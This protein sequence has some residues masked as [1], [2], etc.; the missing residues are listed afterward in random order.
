VKMNRKGSLR[1]IISVLL[2][3][4]GSVIAVKILLFNYTFDSIVPRTGYR[5]HTWM[6]FTG[7]GD[8]LSVKTFIPVNGKRQTISG[9]QIDSPD[10]E[11][12]RYRTTLHSYGEWIRYKADGPYRIDLFY[13]AKITPI[14]YRID[15]GL[16]IT[17]PSDSSLDEYL[18][19][20]DVIQT[21]DPYIHEL[22]GRVVGDNIYLLDILRA[23]YDYVYAMGTRPFKGTTDALTAAKLGEASC[24]GKSRL[25]MAMA[26]HLG[27]PSRL[28]GGLILN[29]GSKK[30]SH[31]WLEVYISGHWVPFDALNGHFAELPGNYLS[32]YRGDEALFRHSPN[33]A[34]DYRFAI[35]RKTVMNNRLD[36]Y[37][38][39]RSFN[40]FSLL[41]GIFKMNISFSVLQFLLVIPLGVVVVT[42][43]RNV[44]G[45]NTFGTF[46]PAL[47]AMS[48]QNTG[49]IPGMIVFLLVILLTVIVRRPLDKLGLLHTPKLA[50]MMIIVIFSLLLISLLSHL[51]FMDIMPSINATA[52]FPIAILTITSE[53]FSISLDED[54][55]K[56]TARIMAQTL[57][58][59]SL[60]Y[61][62]MNSIAVKSI[63]ISFPELLLGVIAFNLWIGSW[64]GIRV[65]ELIRFRSLY[66]ERLH[67]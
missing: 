61:V 21:D 18:G 54:G 13:D 1:L 59:M 15:P 56:A 49:L 52:L 36:S 10:L 40:I 41:S 20:T 50:I 19:A 22:T 7:N 31:Q 60:C 53:R 67:E 12:H 39:E 32:L 63:M 17:P 43:S 3:I 66:L 62:V 57:I 14:A 48:M 24:N 46:L 6:T 8:D 4:M 55:L 23:I 34:F 38:G 47:M 29:R 2:L 9:E 11:F 33:L 37:L 35:N 16:I 64:T 42:I 45:L 30:T 26:R 25:F 58:V 27:I 44:I 65:L 28:V 51:P 5:V